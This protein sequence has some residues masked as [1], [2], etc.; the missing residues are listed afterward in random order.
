MTPIHTTRI[1]SRTQ[2][3][4]CM[5]AIFQARENLFHVDPVFGLFHEVDDELKDSFGD[6]YKL[7]QLKKGYDSKFDEGDIDTHGDRVRK[8][9]GGRLRGFD[10]YSMSEFSIHFHNGGLL[11]AFFQFSPLLE[12]L[13]ALVIPVPW[14]VISV[15]HLLD[16]CHNLTSLALMGNLP[17]PNN[18]TNRA[19]YGVSH[20]NL[21]SLKFDNS[22]Y[23]HLV[24]IGCVAF[25]HLPRLRCLDAGSL[26]FNHTFI[27]LSWWL[28]Q[29]PVQTLRISC[30]SLMEGGGALTV[31]LNACMEFSHYFRIHLK[32]CEA[33]FAVPF[34]RQ[35]PHLLES[36]D[37]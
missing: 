17:P 37:L 32:C 36:V 31:F 11:H 34:F 21:E 8:G 4:Y 2:P 5:N 12:N 30:P 28:K 26:Q 24:Y 15:Q 13:T 6:T 25:P 3:L 27:V 7:S 10:A 9:L 16:R 35:I 1:Y 14:G 19:L 20:D 33:S 29:Q 18:V 22:S 23:L